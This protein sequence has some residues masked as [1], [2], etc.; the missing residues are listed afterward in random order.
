MKPSSEIANLAMMSLDTNSKG[1][2]NSNLQS[3][4]NGKSSSNIQMNSSTQINSSLAITETYGTYDR[5][6]ENNIESIS[7]DC[8]TNLKD[9]RFNGGIGRIFRAKCPSCKSVNRPIYG[10]FIYHPL[11]SICK[12]ASHSGNLNNN[13]PGYIMIEITSGKKI[14]NGSI[15]HDGSSSA[16]FSASSLSF[17]TRVGTTPTKISCNDSPN[18]EPFS[19]GNIGQKFVV[20]CPK[21]CGNLKTQ[22]FGS[23]VYTDT[24]SI[25]ISAIH[26]GVLNDLGGEIEFLIDGPQSFYKGTKS[27]GIIS[28]SEDSYIRSFKFVGVKS[29]IFYKFKEDYQGKIYEKWDNYISSFAKGS[30]SWSYEENFIEINGERKKMSYIKHKGDIKTN[31]KNGFGSLISLKNAQW[32]SGRIKANFLLYNKN[33]FSLFFKYANRNNYYSLQFDPSLTGKNINLVERIE[34][35]I[36]VIESKS[37]KLN[38]NTWY[39]IEIIM[40]NDNITINMQNDSIREKKMIFKRLLDKIARGTIAFAS[41]GNDDLLINGVEIDDYQNQSSDWGIKNRRSWIE[42]LKHSNERSKKLYCMKTYRHEKTEIDSCLIPQNYCKLK[43]DEYIPETENI[44]N[45]SC[46]KDCIQKIRIEKNEIKVEKSFDPQIND[47][48]DFVPKGNSSYRPGIIVDRKYKSLDNGEK[49]VKY[50][51]SF[52]DGIENSTQGV[53]MSEKRLFKCSTILLA[54]ND[55]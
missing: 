50:F 33:S 7:L 37:I 19:N 32:S 47:K 30:N 34:G 2:A 39:R 51:V 24:S 9:K 17:K 16:T 6:D 13:Q 54:R 18:K 49:Q 21:N 36:Q 29:A 41:N 11:S 31:I 10:S 38:L 4:S 26:A 20:I 48:V 53:F 28:S 35:S 5:K 44:L 23:E 3:N 14:F 12:A 55:C 43:C 1:Q 40:S 42:L 22:I 27:F 8:T 25:C 46:W 45:F 52:N 15:G